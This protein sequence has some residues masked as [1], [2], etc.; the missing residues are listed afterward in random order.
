M[1]GYGES[2]RTGCLASAS[3]FGGKEP[4]LWRRPVGGKMITKRCYRLTSAYN[5]ILA[6]RTN[7]KPTVMSGDEGTTDTPRARP[8]RPFVTPNRY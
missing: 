8:D 2:R 1:S 4:I 3:A 5:E 6:Y 7:V